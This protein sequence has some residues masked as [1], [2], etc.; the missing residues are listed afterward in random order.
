MPRESLRNAAQ[1]SP[2]SPSKKNEVFVFEAP[3]HVPFDAPLDAPFA[4]SAISRSAVVSRIVALVQS[5]SLE[6]SSRISTTRRAA[7]SNRKFA[8]QDDQFTEISAPPHIDTNEIQQVYVGTHSVDF[9][10][11]INAFHGIVELSVQ[12]SKK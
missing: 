12:S 8:R 6:T 4:C 3:L 7:L 10:V 11:D 9:A 2:S 5:A 1:I